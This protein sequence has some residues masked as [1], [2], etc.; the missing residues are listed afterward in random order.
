ML[1]KQ[2]ESINPS[3][4]GPLFRRLMVEENLG[5]L[6]EQNG[7]IGFEVDLSVEQE[8]SGFLLVAIK[9]H[10]VLAYRSDLDEEPRLILFPPID[11]L[12]DT[13]FNMLDLHIIKTL[14]TD[15]DFQG[16][17]IE[18]GRFALC[19]KDLTPPEKDI[20]IPD[21]VSEQMVRQMES[22]R[23]SSQPFTSEP[24]P[25][26]E[27]DAEPVVENVPMVDDVATFDDAPG[28]EDDYQEFDEPYDDYQEFDEPYDDM[29]QEFDEPYDDMHQEF[30]EPEPEPEP[31]TD[32]RSDQLREQTFKHLA[33]VGDYV[34]VKFNVPKTITA[35]VVN[36]ALQSDVVANKQIDSKKLAVMLFCKLFDDGKI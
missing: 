8:L 36:K 3:A 2:I 20:D 10:T 32:P 6:R 17:V 26:S 31:A 18:K 35:Q 9:K 4:K 7:I 16:K 23:S 15:K 30:D 29:H 34:H 13:T 28:F 1:R 24:E 12:F 33:D 14:F 11:K 5:Y 25:K 27:P 21:S 22:I 19:V